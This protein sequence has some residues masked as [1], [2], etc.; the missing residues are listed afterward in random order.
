MYKIFLK[1]ELNRIITY[2]IVPLTKTLPS[3]L[4][5]MQLAYQGRIQNKLVPRLH[6]GAG[7]NIDI[8]FPWGILVQ[9]AN[10][11]TLDFHQKV[12]PKINFSKYK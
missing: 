8:G 7:P 10:V 12:T 5:F 2:S 9:G 4:T 3:I 1:I 11:F 6:C